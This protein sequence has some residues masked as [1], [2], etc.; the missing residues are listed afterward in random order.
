MTITSAAAATAVVSSGAISSVAVDQAGFRIHGPLGH[1]H[2]S[3]WRYHRL[4]AALTASGGVDSL[5]IAV[6]GGGV[7]E[8][9]PLLTFSAPEITGGVQATGLATGTAIVGSNP[10]RYAVTDVTVL[11]PGSGY[12]SAPTVTI[13][14]GSLTALPRILA[15]VTATI[16][17]SQIDVTTPGSLLHPRA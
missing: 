17:I 3:G 9:Q 5:S 7:F 8:I 14:D 10:V 11:N 16:D 4:G 6:G 2:E 13:Y 12:T 1:P 15:D